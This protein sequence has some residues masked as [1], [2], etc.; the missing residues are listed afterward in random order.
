M[1]P[2]INPSEPLPL[3]ISWAGG[4]VRN[5]TYEQVVKI[6]KYLRTQHEKCLKALNCEE[7][8]ELDL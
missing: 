8:M 2:H 4:C 1:I 5:P 3:M 7:I 6:E